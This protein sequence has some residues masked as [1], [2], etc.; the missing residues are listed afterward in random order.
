MKEKNIYI[1]RRKNMMRKAT[2]EKNI[3]EKIYNKTP[4]FFG[5]IWKFQMDFKIK[6]HTHLSNHVQ[7]YNKDFI[8]ASGSLFAICTCPPI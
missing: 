2:K 3:D 4:R 6:T 8:C 1:K 5:Y 7:S